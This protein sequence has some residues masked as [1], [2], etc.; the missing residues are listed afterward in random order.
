[1]F[2]KVIFPPKELTAPILKVCEYNT[3][4]TSSSAH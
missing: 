4:D 1:L 2:S 3:A